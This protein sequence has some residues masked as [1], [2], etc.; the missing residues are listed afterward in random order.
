MIETERLTL[1]LFTPGDADFLY[2]VFSRPEVARWSGD[3]VPIA[4]RDEALRR[5]ASQPKRAGDHPAAGI[6]ARQRQGDRDP[7]GHGPVRAAPA[8]RGV[9]P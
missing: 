4:D 1:R 2:D 5:I 8:Q 3:G 6:F 7:G 9:R